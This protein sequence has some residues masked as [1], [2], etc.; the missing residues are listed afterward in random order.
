M[1]FELVSKAS[2]QKGKGIDGKEIIGFLYE[3]TKQCYA[4]SPDGS[5]AYVR[6]E[7]D[8]KYNGCN[9]VINVLVKAG[10]PYVQIRGHSTKTVENGILEVEF[11]GNSLISA[12]SFS[13]SA[14][15]FR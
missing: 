10:T 6:Y 1:K 9:A 14:I 15:L 13:I 8:P 4:V 3:L 11:Y 7:V 2:Y 12:H 5:A